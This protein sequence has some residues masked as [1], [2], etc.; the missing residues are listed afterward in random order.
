MELIMA[1]LNRGV[2][3]NAS[4]EDDGYEDESSKLL[5]NGHA[6]YA[7]HGSFE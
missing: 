2:D 7:S 6:D 3:V 4:D 1:F 5:M